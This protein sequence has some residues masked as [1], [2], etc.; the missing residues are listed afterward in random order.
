MLPDNLI[1]VIERN[2]A[3]QRSRDTT[4]VI[5]E[6]YVVTVVVCILCVKTK[7]YYYI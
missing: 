1:I 7:L 6:K 5:I 3:S 4:P 2:I